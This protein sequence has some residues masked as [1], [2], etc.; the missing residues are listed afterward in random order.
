VDL[1]H[2]ALPTQRKLAVL[3]AETR[4]LAGQGIAGGVLLLQQHQGDAWTLEL[5]VHD[6]EVGCELVAA[7]GQRWA[8]ARGP[9]KRL[10]RGGQIGAVSVAE[11]S[12]HAGRLPRFIA[13]KQPLKLRFPKAADRQ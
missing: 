5:L 3:D 2:R 12:G 6:T 4:V 10:L 7:A 11:G 1:A 9:H 13:E 8:V